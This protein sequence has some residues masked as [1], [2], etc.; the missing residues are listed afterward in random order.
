MSEMRTHELEK[1]CEMYLSQ[2]QISKATLKSY[3][4]AF[5]LYI[6]YLKD[7]EITYAK[8][9]DVIKYREHKRTIGHSP[10]YIHV[11]LCAL[12]GLYQYLKANQHILNISEFYL[13]NVME[14]I[15][16]ETIHYHI[17]KPILTLEQAKHLI[18]HTKNIRKSIWHFRD[19]AIV[20]LMITA[21]LRSIEIIQAKREDYQVLDGKQ[22]LYIR[23]KEKHKTVQYVY[24]TPGVKLAIDEYLEKRK[25]DNPFLFITTKN[26]SPQRCL[27]RTFFRY[28]FARVFKDCG[29]AEL[30]ITP[31]A[32]RHTAGIMNLLRGGSV[33]A[34]QSL[35]R[36]A[37]IKSTLVYQDYLEHV[38]N[39]TELEIER[40]ILKEETNNL[41]Q[42]IIVYLES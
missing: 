31:H 8:T 23:E 6:N 36:H 22:V 17:N 11:H 9:S 18:L 21:G 2:K 25:D 30:G 7:N 42:S 1:L 32:L 13:F 20:F 33:E 3:R 5:K 24:I 16:N 37:H 28:M 34:T 26:V 19:H 27:S 41:Y 29:Y 15:K 12:K 40:F 38:N 35:L 39:H 4:I 10:Q 14:G